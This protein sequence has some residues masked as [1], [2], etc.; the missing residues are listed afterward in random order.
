MVPADHRYA[1][2]LLR[3]HCED[4]TRWPERVRAMQENWIGC[5]TGARVRF[6][7]AAA[8]GRDRGGRG[9][10]DAPRHAIRHV[11]PR[12]RAGASAGRRGRGNATRRLPRSSPS[13]GASG[14]SEAVIETAEKEGYDT[15]LRVAHPFIEGATFPVWIA[16]FVLMEYGTGAMFGCP[17][18][19]QR[20]LEFARKYGSARGAGRAAA[21][22]TTRRRSRSATRPMTGR[23]RSSIRVPRRAGRRTRPSASAI[24]A[25]ERAAASARASRTGGCATGASAASATGAARSRSSIARPAASCRCPTTSCR[26]A[27]RGRA[28]RRP[29][30]PLD[31]HPTWK[32]VACPRCGGGGAAR[33]RHVRHVRRQLLVFRALLQP[34]RGRAGGA[35]RRPITGCRSTSTSAASSTRSCTCST[36]ASSP[37]RCS[38]TGHLGVDGAV[39]RAVHAGHGDARELPRGGRALALSRGGGAAPGRE[40]RSHRATGEPVTV[41]R[42]EAMSKSKRNTVDPGAIIARYG[43]DTAALVHPVGQPARARHG[44]D[45]GR[46]RRGVPLHPA[47]V[48]A[49]RCGAAAR[50]AGCGEL[51]PQRGAALAL[52]RATHRTIAAVTEALEGFA[53]NVAVARLYELANAIADAE[54]GASGDGHGDGA[55]R[56]AVEILARLLS[57]M[58]PH[59]A[60][61]MHARLQSRGSALVADLPWPEADAVAGAAEAVTIAVQVMGKLRGTI[62]AVPDADPPEV[63]AAAEAE[64]NVARLLA[65]QANRQAHPRAEQDRQFRGRGLRMMRRRELLASSCAGLLAWRGAVSG[66]STCR[67]LGRAGIAQREL[68]AVNVGDHCPTARASCCARRCRSGW[69]ARAAGSPGNTISA[70]EL[71]HRRGGYRHP[72]GQLRHPHPPDRA[73]R[74]GHSGRR[75]RAARR[76]ARGSARAIDGLNILDQQFFAADLENEAVQRR[77]AEQIADQIVLQLAAYFR[78]PR[79]RLLPPG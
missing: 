40:S 56:E 65:G 69:K 14:T 39:R 26:C 51:W 70:V 53:F 7:L 38:D 8:G 41:G 30:N 22:R 18:H 37:A 11:L 29:G 10:Y 19:D 77:L 6:R 61:E 32:H 44:V 54:R 24:A 73:R 17:A 50:N 13:A 58:M 63:L 68:G 31:H 43:A 76:L 3:R 57:P 52:R 23:A 27:A 55:R 34:A 46:G 20:D 2:E 5:S 9:L 15:G 42:V 21:R 36:R 64:P 60:E 67:R 12:A 66:R 49:G 74:T 33:D 45:R 4:L 35:A 25:L 72:A 75:T 71:Q 28:L 47:G 48:P 79:R 62:E 59:L 78:Q 16:N 1:E